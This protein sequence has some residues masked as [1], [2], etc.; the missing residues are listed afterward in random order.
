[1]DWIV[2]DGVEK[3]YWNGRG[4]SSAHSVAGSVD[5]KRKCDKKDI[6][7]GASILRYGGQRKRIVGKRKGLHQWLA[8]NELHSN[9]HISSSCEYATLL[10]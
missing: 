9:M 8:L 10:K 1:M 4:F 3:Y 2:G 6:H 5:L 7:K